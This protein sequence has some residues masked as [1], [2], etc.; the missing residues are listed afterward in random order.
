MEVGVVAERSGG[1]AWR[2]TPEDEHRQEEG[3]GSEAAGQWTQSDVA[4]VP[5]GLS[6]RLVQVLDRTADRHIIVCEGPGEDS[7]MV[8][9]RLSGRYPHVFEASLAVH[10]A[11]G[12]YACGVGD[13]TG[14]SVI[15]DGV[16][17]GRY[18]GVSAQAPPVFS[19]DGKHV[20]YG[21]TTSRQ[22]R[23][24]VAQLCL[25]G[26]LTDVV[27]AAAPL[28]FA[29]DGRLVYVEVDPDGPRQRVV[30]G[31][32][33]GPWVTDVLQFDDPV[34]WPTPES[35]PPGPVAFSR[36]GDFAYAV[37]VPG[38]QAVA[39]NHAIGPV[40]ER[41]H[42]PAYCG[43]R[44]TYICSRTEGRF[45][46]RHRSLA[47]VVDEVPGPWFPYIAPGVAEDRF[48][49]IAYL[50]GPSDA[51]ARLHL[52]HAAAGPECDVWS[53]VHATPSGRL[54]FIAT[55][56]GGVRLVLDGAAGPPGEELPPASVRESPD[57]TR[58]GHL[59]RSGGGFTAGG[60]CRLVLDGRALDL[61]VDDRFWSRGQGFNPAGI[62]AIGVSSGQA[63]RPWVEGHGLGPAFDE[64]AGP[65]W[66]RTDVRFLAMR[67]GRAVQLTLAL[68]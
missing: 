32:S 68:Q 51:S 67:E 20:A 23:G 24:A 63:L 47:V 22:R 13:E 14:M 40:R 52:D 55:G 41:V 57:G 43:R 21:V 18:L 15:V 34:V 28:S 30:V 38:G 65:W 48:G 31:G 42:L 7:L 60:T 2:W 9:G 36:T 16:E 4:V 33:P 5:A 26:T 25:D 10:A 29:P 62:A 39:V 46:A 12:R 17:Q 58:V 37:E 54:W 3:L 53:G 49:R 56:E 8:D 45:L 35:P 1:L 61:E 6:A 50:A 19:P 11:T 27:L 59:L 44:L 66:T 64:V